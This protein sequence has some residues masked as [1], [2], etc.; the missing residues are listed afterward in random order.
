MTDHVIEG[1]K[2]IGHQYAHAE[3][4]WAW[5]TAT[6]QPMNELESAFQQL[7]AIELPT[8]E[9]AALDLLGRI[10]GAPALILD[11][12]AL[13]LFGFDGQDNA[14]PFGET[15]NPTT[16]GHWRESGDTGASTVVLTEAMYRL[17]ITAQILRN[18]NDC[19][20]NEII[21]I[22]G[23]L[24][25]APWAYVDGAMWIG[26]GMGAGGM[27]LLE[28]RLI[29]EFLPRPAGVGLRFFAGWID[30]FGWSDQPDSLG[31][32]DTAD[33]AVGGFWTE[34]IAA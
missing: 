3:K 4:F 7:L 22:V 21:D 1:L 24:T 10:V 32:G 27:S 13:P 14:Q 11:A 9:G 8:A 17:A 19:T 2:R 23:V 30:G 20:P 26:I 16:G 25:S 29:E 5:V 6:L 18:H 28:R 31:F 34:E 15:S 12:E 33:T